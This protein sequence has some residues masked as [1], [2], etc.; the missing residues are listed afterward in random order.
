MEQTSSGIAQIN[1]NN[2]SFNL[3]N[4]A[5]SCAKQLIES[6]MIAKVVITKLKQVLPLNSNNLVYGIVG[7]GSNRKQYYPR[8]VS[9]WSN[10][11]SI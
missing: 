10:N 2:I 6:P 9:Y 5:Y 4:I 7:L 1:N 8:A 3:I 11:N